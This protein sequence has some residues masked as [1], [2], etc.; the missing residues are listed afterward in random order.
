MALIVVVF[1]LGAALFVV[2]LNGLQN[3]GSGGTQL[4]STPMTTYD[5]S[6]IDPET[7]SV[8]G[9]TTE[10]WFGG[11]LENDKLDT[12]TDHL[13]ATNFS[14]D[15]DQ[16]DSYGGN[17]SFDADGVP[18]G[19]GEKSTDLGAEASDGDSSE[20]P[21]EIEEADIIKLED[22]TL[23][24]LNS[25]R[26]LII[27][28]I[29]SP[30]DPVIESRVPLF[31]APVDMYIVEP[32]AYIIM[33]HYYNAFLWAEDASVEPKYRH[34]S[35]IVIVDIS[36]HSKPV[37]Q[38]Y[39]ELDGFIT[40]SRRVGEVIYAVANTENGYFGFM[41]GIGTVEV[42]IGVTD[43]VDMEGTDSS[44]EIVTDEKGIIDDEEEEPPEITEGTVVVSINMEDLT[45]IV[46]ADREIFLGTSNEI[47]VTENAI[48]V[49]KP[50]YNYQEDETGFSYRYYTEVTYVDIS[51]RH[52]EIKL[53][54]TFQVEG[55]LQDRYQM[56]YF[57]NTFRIVT[58]FQGNWQNLGES[59]LW[60]FDTTNP[61][62]ITKLGE[63]LIDDAGTLMATRFA[64]E[65]AY[66]IH[67]PR[68]IDPLD[69]LDLSNP[70]EPKLRSIFEMPGWI[71]HMEVR[72]YKILGLGVDDS[73]GKNN[74]AVSL[75][76]VTDPEKPEMKERVIIG[77]GYSWST[78]NWD[79]KA[80]TVVDDQSLILVP[81]ESYSYDEDG[82]YKPFSGIQIVE[83]DLENNDLTL[84]GAIEQMGTVQR[85]RA[86]DERI[87]AISNQQLQVINAKSRDKPI[88]TA[89]LELCNNVIDAIPMGNYVVQ[90]I[91]DYDYS[92]RKTVTKFHT[93]PAT[94]PDTMV[95][96]A[97]KKV[98]YNINRIFTNNNYLYLICSEYSTT[99]QTTNGRIVV[100][101]YTQPLFPKILSNFVMDYYSDYYYYWYYDS[102]YY[103]GYS[104]PQDSAT[105]YTF[106]QVSDDLIVYHPRPGYNNIYYKEPVGDT[107]R[108]ETE[109]EKTTTNGGASI[110]YE[111]WYY[112][113][114][115][116]TETLY[117]IDLSNPIKPK[118]AAKV[119]LANVARISGMHAK[120]DTLY[121]TQYHT[122]SI[123]DQY[124]G[125]RYTSKN[126]LTTLDLSTPTE[127]A[128]S[129][130]INI[131]GSFI[132]VNDAGTVVY[133]RSSEYD[134]N[135][136]WRQTL[137]VLELGEEGA[138]LKSVIDLGDEYPSILVSDTTLILSYNNYYY[139]SGYYYEEDVFDVDLGA[140]RD[141]Q[142][143]EP[144]YKTKIQIIDASDPSSLK[145]KATI[146]LK[147]YGSV[148]K[149][150][151]DK[152][153]IQLS[154]A[155]GLLI[156]DL[157]DLGT[158]A[159]LGYFPVHGWVSSIRENTNSGKVYL[160][161]G[162]YGVMMIDLSQ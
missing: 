25:Y 115:Q 109:E 136:N 16:R 120:G 146:G 12:S 127:P 99:E 2:N 26:G 62:D 15:D 68:R 58:H 21:R 159:F 32:R 63:L 60:I 114:T 57:E 51:D 126:F 162:W 64:G 143:Q 156:Y 106:V 121:L 6:V 39:I 107:N 29:S 87:F 18:D 141:D 72:G 131:P 11:L 153:Y 104:Y 151:N 83:F 147:N 81:F 123:Y 45:N 91:S 80:L 5:E 37:V 116:V 142:I 71:T 155:N 158:P 161:C 19:D 24:I 43:D 94:D 111:G 130:P 122:E 36:D 55:S 139:W 85:T 44:E 75:F 118:D 4:D 42:A 33:T 96:L 144:V 93:V 90:V 73:D 79:P 49:A 74:V 129:D 145:L 27:V 23:Y 103:G 101:D 92:V 69:V 149:F 38:K 105:E 157:N 135:Y 46:E 1:L 70:R 22:D 138:T 67:L 108:N 154:D 3:G 88:V 28:D 7:N 119:T 76:D 17:N 117:I 20:P 47:H 125:W 124:Y 132:G 97:E 54:D 128:V 13:G 9:L 134:E 48:F 50:E 52:G 152:L 41:D 40:D 84:G 137:N 10:S 133:T 110:Y 112:E 86:N 31:G 95:F 61:D 102:Y 14:T 100:L 53:R 113:D 78:A 56:D 82:N 98:D 77:E 30:D 35:E 65:R 89:T 150:E 140:P 66:T 8:N 59:K 160:A 148:F 34:G